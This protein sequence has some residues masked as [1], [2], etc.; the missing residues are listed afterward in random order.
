[1]TATYIMAFKGKA[2]HHHVLASKHTTTVDTPISLAKWGTNYNTSEEESKHVLLQKH[3]RASFVY[4]LFDLDAEHFGQDLVIYSPYSISKIWKYYHRHTLAQLKQWS[5]HSL[6]KL[7]IR[8]PKMQLQRRDQLKKLLKMRH[9]SLLGAL[10]GVFDEQGR[11]FQSM[12]GWWF[13]VVH[14]QPLIRTPPLMAR[15]CR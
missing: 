14:Y 15:M 13:K 7:P 2:L 10:P 3:I 4:W 8:I 5:T 1:M 9:H 6:E 11:E 12:V